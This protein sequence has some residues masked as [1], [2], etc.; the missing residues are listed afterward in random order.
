[1]AVDARVGCECGHNVAKV[2]EES[3]VHFHDVPDQECQME[4]LQLH[5][6]GVDGPSGLGMRVVAITQLGPGVE[7]ME[8]TKDVNHTC[9][10]K[11]VRVVGED[12]RRRC[13]QIVSAWGPC[14]CRFGSFLQRTCNRVSIYFDGMTARISE[15]REGRRRRRWP[16]ALWVM[17][18]GPRHPKT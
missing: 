15:A 13:R 6:P 11:A 18:H 5:A 12:R 8:V 17:C 1:L 7:M 16:A 9:V 3:D 4:G 2:G 10:K 14:A